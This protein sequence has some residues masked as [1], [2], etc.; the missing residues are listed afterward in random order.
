[1]CRPVRQ[2]TGKAHADRLEP[3]VLDIYDDID[4]R[5][6]HALQID[7]R[8][9]FRRVAEV[10]GV[11]DQT[12]AR[13]Y[14]RL[15]EIG[16]VRVVALGAPDVLRDVHWTVRIRV[17]P[18]GLDEVAAALARRED[19]G[20]IQAC[21]GGA[22]IVGSV[23]GRERD[24]ELL[25][26]LPTTAGVRD[27]QADRVLRV[28]YGGPGQPFTKHGPLDDAQVRELARHLPAPG[29]PPARLDDTDRRLLAVLREDGRTG[30]D[31]IARLVGVS[32]GTARRRL[33]DLRAGGALL[34]D[35]DV[36]LDVLDLATHT[37]VRLAVHPGELTAA[38]TRLAG[39]P[40]VAYAAATTGTTNLFASV[41]TADTAELYR[42]L[43][44]AVAELPGLRSVETTPVQRT[45]KAERTAYVGAGP[46]RRS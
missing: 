2:M 22:E 4:R 7:A 5:L 33:G 24:P 25:R 1:M 12:V 44:T 10:L 6:V 23:H 28:F 32:T 13:R 17:D 31:R 46:A 35:V 14:G 36:G 39:L 16:A 30:V 26:A 34:F 8:A 29:A 41:T 45:Y 20:W 27:V 21:S 19:T 15:R 42:F 38:G 43:T 40:E 3:M 18:A 9:P 11:S 37:L